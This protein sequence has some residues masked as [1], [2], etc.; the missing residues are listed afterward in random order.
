[1]MLKVKGPKACGLAN[2]ENNLMIN[3]WWHTNCKTIQ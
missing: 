3:W 1:M 2:A